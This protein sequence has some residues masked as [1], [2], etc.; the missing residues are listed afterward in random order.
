MES[1]RG[2]L[3]EL[4]Y[5]LFGLPASALTGP[6]S[7]RI[8]LTVSEYVPVAP[9]SAHNGRVRANLGKCG[10][11]DSICFPRGDLAQTVYYDPGGRAVLRDH[12]PRQGRMR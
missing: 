4:R 12:K 10:V 3:C 6:T 1:S 5:R 9:R 11:L 8:A 2:L 7:S